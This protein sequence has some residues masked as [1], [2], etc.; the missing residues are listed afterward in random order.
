MTGGIILDIIKTAE[1]Y[2]KIRETA[3]GKRDRLGRKPDSLRLY[4]LSGMLLFHKMWRVYSRQ[5][6]IY[7]TGAVAL[8]ALVNANSV[9]FSEGTKNSLACIIYTKDKHFYDNIGE[10]E[11]LA[12]RL[13][14]LR[15]LKKP[16]KEIAPIV[17]A[18]SNDYTSRFR[19]KVPERF[20]GEHEVFYTSV[21]VCRSHF[22]QNKLSERS[23]PV[24][25]TDSGEPEAIIMPYWYW[26]SKE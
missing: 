4:N 14:E 24:L 22:P 3:G 13:M 25:V 16:I 18:V 12:G 23:F 21:V 6:R 10:F 1:E 19:L 15:G 8:G 17:R 11:R 9:L 2:E 26:V 20:A 7:Q 5:K